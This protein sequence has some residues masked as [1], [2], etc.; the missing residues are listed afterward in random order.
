M[1]RYHRGSGRVVDGGIKGVFPYRVPSG[2]LKLAKK[3]VGKYG[4]SLS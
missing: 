3:Y 4:L 1:P 2:D